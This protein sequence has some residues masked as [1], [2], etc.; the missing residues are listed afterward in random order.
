MLSPRSNYYIPCQSNNA[1]N[2][3]YSGKNRN[4]RYSGVMTAKPKTKTVIDNKE[5]QTQAKGKIFHSEC[6]KRLE[7]LF[8]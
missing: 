3:E 5:T 6:K 1:S 8:P 2:Y 4:N 7:F